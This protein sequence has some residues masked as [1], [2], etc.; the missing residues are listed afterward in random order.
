MSEKSEITFAM[1][2]RCNL[3]VV[4]DGPIEEATC[5]CE[6]KFIVGIESGEQYEVAISKHC[7]MGNMNELEGKL[8]RALEGRLPYYPQDGLSLGYWLN[9]WAHDDLGNEDQ[10]LNYYVLDYIVLE[11]GCRITLF[12]YSQDGRFFGEISPKYPIMFSA[13]EDDEGNYPAFCE[14]MKSYKPHC[15]I[16][17]DRDTLRRMLAEVKL[18]I[19][20]I[21]MNTDGKARNED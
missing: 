5:C 7:I 11:Y 2:D 3:K 6:S 16:P 19:D 9:R 1:G 14:F 18:L 15:I 17:T 4:F 12:L 21:L 20:M 10:N 13:K 8:E